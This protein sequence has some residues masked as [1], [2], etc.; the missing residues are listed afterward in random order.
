MFQKLSHV[1]LL[2]KDQNDALAFYQG[3]LGFK[4]HTDV[5][6]GDLRWLTLHA[7]DQSDVELSLMLAAPADQDV[8]GRQGGSYPFIALLTTDCRETVKKLKALGIQF[9]GEPKEEDWGVGI[10]FKDLYGNLI[11][12]VESK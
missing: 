7:P 10:T 8:V 5:N 11:Y 6:F 12:L 9:D 3:K 1:T 2:V 4:V